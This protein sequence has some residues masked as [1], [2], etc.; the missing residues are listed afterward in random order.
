M[1]NVLVAVFDSAEHARA[2]H[3]TLLQQGFRDGQVAVDSGPEATEE[4][5]LAGL[6][7]RM[8]SGL[9]PGDDPRGHAYTER[10]GQGGGIV[11]IHDVDDAAE[12]RARAILQQHGAVNVESHAPLAKSS[13]PPAAPRD[14]R[15][16]SELAAVASVGGPQAYVLPNAPTDWGRFTGRSRASVGQADDPARPQGELRDAVGLDP[17]A[18]VEN[19]KGQRRG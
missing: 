6:V 2:A 12:A 16:P 10:L 11:A 13:A 19:L 1:Q 4:R 18:D 9:L 14:A 15:A 5:G 8:F 3:A 17:E 7:A